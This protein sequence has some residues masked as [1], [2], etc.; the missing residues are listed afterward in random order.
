MNTKLLKNN[1]TYTAWPFS[2]EAELEDAIQEVK[3]H[4]FGNTR[5]YLEVKRKI[6][7]QGGKQNIPDAYII[8]LSSTK[9][10][11]LFVVENEL[12]SHHYLKHIAV[13]ILEFSLAFK[14]NPQRVKEVIREALRN[15]KDAEAKVKQYAERN[16]FENIDYLLE[17]IVHHKEAFNALVIIDSAEPDLQN[18]LKDEFRFPVDLLTLERFRSSDKKNVIYKF[19]PLLSDLDNSDDGSTLPSLDPSELDTIV[20][21]AQEDGFR[22]VFLGEKRWY[23]IRISASMIPQI[24]WLAVYQ[25]APISAITHIA[26][27]GSIKPYKDSDKYELIFETKAQELEKAI[28]L[29]PKSTVKSILSPRYTAYDRLNEAT[30]LNEVF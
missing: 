4:L 9:A 23:S 1:T 24:K 29:V 7:K 12:S 16:G 17:K 11:K 22:D 15:E 30:N 19:D 13:Q 5:I 21:P 20:V 3:A 26:K 6:G 27:V 8:D 14:T 25:V 18:V 10:P 2:K 28:K